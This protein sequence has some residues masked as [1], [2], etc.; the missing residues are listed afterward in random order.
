MYD[1]MDR[2]VTNQDRG[3]RFIV[4]SL[5][6]WIKAKGQG[7]CPANLLAPAFSKWDMLSGL[8]PFL[9]LLALLDRHG[10]VR[11]QFCA[12]T[13]NHVSEHEA[14]FINLVRSL[15][16]QQASQVRETLDLLIEEE[17]VGDLLH[18]LTR[19]GQALDGAGIYPR[20]QP[21]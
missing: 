15:R 10:L 7:R 13:C 12:L 6:T 17:A 16:E 11:F 21:V 18:A 20:A 5:R 1:L 3:T 9:R 19:L 14:I 8:Q 2:P 4:W